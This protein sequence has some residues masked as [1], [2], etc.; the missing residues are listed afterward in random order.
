MFPFAQSHN[1]LEQRRSLQKQRLQH[2]LQL[3]SQQIERVMNAHRLPARVSGGKVASQA[4]QFDLQTQLQGGWERVRSLTDDLR[5][6]LGV[7]QISVFRENGRLQVAVARD[8]DVPVRLLDVLAMGMDIGQ[9]TAV[10][11]LSDEGVPVLLPMKEHVLLTGVDGAGKTSILRSIAVSLALSNRQSQL[12]Q[13]IIAPIF[14]H[15]NAYS[16]LRPLTILPHLSAYIAFRIEE[17]DQLLTWLVADMENRLRL[18]ESSPAVV[19]MIDHVVEL[20][21]MGGE[22]I[23]EAVTELLQRGCKAGIHLLLTT[24][25]PDSDILDTHL[26]AN[27]PW[28]IIGKATDSNQAASASGI[29]NSEAEYLLGRGDFLLLKDEKRVYFQAAY[30]EDYDLHMSLKS[31]QGSN[32]ISILAQPFTVRYKL[33]VIDSEPI[34]TSFWIRND[35]ENIFDEEE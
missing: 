21:D 3:Q 31:L 12:Q 15:N 23:V 9:K 29:E 24:P 35:S 28:R 11:G 17:A 20:M 25:W 10:L 18:G 30:I 2:R 5:Q 33:P 6:A 19:L 22:P 16:D 8:A 32:K 4:I 13:I 34:P 14:E 27:L 26:K 1:N 7:P